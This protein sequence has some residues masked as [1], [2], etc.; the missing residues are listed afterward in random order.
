MLADVYVSLYIFLHVY[1]CLCVFAYF[2]CVFVHIFGFSSYKIDRLMC[3]GRRLLNY[4]FYMKKIQKYIQKH[5]KKTQIHINIC[6]H[7]ETYVKKYEHLRD[8]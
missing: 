1:I 2:L 8:F 4:Q 7:L 6:K 3:G 5:A